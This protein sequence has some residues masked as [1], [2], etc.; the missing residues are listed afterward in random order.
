MILE[1]FHHLPDHTKHH[2]LDILVV[3]VGWGASAVSIMNVVNPLLTALVLGLTVILTV[4]RI[5]AIL[6]DRKSKKDEE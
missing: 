6:E 4:M 2:L 5:V 3:T 1:I